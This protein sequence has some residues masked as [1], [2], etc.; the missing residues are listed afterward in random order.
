MNWLASWYYFT[1]IRLTC[2]HKENPCTED[3]VVAWLV[4]LT[5]SDAQASHEEQDDAEDGEYAGGSHRT[6]ESAEDSG[7]ERKE[8]GEGRMGCDLV[9]TQRGQ[10]PVGQQR[11]RRQRHKWKEWWV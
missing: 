9:F 4:E 6:W 10:Q 3:D 5:G 8:G 11:E 1:G 7:E 2:R